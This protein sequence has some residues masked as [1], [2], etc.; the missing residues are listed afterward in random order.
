MK[1][2]FDYGQEKQQAQRMEEKLLE[3]LRAHVGHRSAIEARELARLLGERGDR[4]VRIAIATLRKRGYLILSSV[5]KPPGYFMAATYGEWQEFRR[6]MRSRALDILETD[7]AMLGAAEAQFSPE[8]VRVREG[9][10]RQLRLEFA[11]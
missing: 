11:V 7:A 4:R 6:N 2:A 8:K 9:E 3:I 1:K 5:G 10:A